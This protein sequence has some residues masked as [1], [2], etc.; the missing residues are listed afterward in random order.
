MRPAMDDVA[1]DEDALASRP[2]R[3]NVRSMPIQLFTPSLSLSLYN[4]PTPRV[5]GHQALPL[6]LLTSVHPEQSSHSQIC[7]V[8]GQR[9]VL[10]RGGAL[11]RE[12][13][14]EF[15]TSNILRR[16]K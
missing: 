9:G 4:R 10:E 16:W 11:A 6:V 8:A 2:P 15:A 7:G 13:L 5:T 3:Y 14:N 1:F 12:D